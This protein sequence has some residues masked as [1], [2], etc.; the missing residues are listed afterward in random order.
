M[1]FWGI[2]LNFD[3]FILKKVIELGKEKNI[4]FLLVVGGG[5]VIDGIKLIFVGIFYNGDVWELVKKGSV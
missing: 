1:E 2:E 4:D 5:L 3:I